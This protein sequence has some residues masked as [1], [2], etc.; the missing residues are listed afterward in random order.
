MQNHIKNLECICYDLQ[1]SQFASKDKIEALETRLAAVEKELF[2]KLR[3][4]STDT[5]ERERDA[6]KNI[7]EMQAKEDSI[8][9]AKLKSELTHERVNNKYLKDVVITGLQKD[10]RETCDRNAELE[11]ENCNYWQEIEKL[12]MEFTEERKINKLLK[13]T[14]LQL[15]EKNG[16]ANKDPV[17]L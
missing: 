2:P 12:K 5:Y 11:K 10:Y 16:E 13:K 8:Y 14:N 1:Q 17:I 3:I 15:L 6:A 4:M 9:I 7:Y